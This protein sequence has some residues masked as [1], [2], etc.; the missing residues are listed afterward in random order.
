MAEYRQFIHSE[1]KKVVTCEWRHG[2][3]ECSSDRE[4]RFNVCTPK[5]EE[6]Y[7]DLAKAGFQEAA[8]GAAPPPVL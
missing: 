4:G 7:W 5:I 6:L 8:N 2:A 3:W 1:D